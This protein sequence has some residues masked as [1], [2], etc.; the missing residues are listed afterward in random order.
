[1]L[2]FCGCDTW[3]VYLKCHLYY[4]PT[5]LQLSPMFKLEKIEQASQLTVLIAVGQNDS[6]AFHGQALAYSKVSILIFTNKVYRSK[7]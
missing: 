6:P 7:D 5:A 4:R 3:Q 2:S 1:M